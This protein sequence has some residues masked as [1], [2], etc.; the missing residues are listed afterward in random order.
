M[1]N[2]WNTGSKKCVHLSTVRHF[3]VRSCK[4][5]VGNTPLTHMF[6]DIFSAP[7]P[8]SIWPTLQR[9]MHTFPQFTQ[10]LL[11]TTTGYSFNKL[12]IIER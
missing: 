1:E 8:V 11:Y 3:L 10:H 12:L 6:F 9:Q 2:M 4:Y 5:Y 7:F